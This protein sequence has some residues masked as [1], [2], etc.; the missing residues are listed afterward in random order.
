LFGFVPFPTFIPMIPIHEFKDKKHLQ[1]VVNQLGSLLEYDYTAPHRHDYFELFIFEKGGGTH[2]I[3]FEAFPIHD[4]SIHIVAPGKVHQ[5]NR[6]LNSNGYVIL[7]HAALLND[8][9]VGDFLFNHTCYSVQE[10]TPNYL[11]NEQQQMQICE[12]ANRIWEDYIADH[13]LKQEFVLHHLALL[14]LH[15]LRAR[16]AF[17][18]IQ[19]SANGKIYQ[20]FRKLLYRSFRELKKVKDYAALL[21]V[22][23]KQLN[24][25]V[26]TQTGNSASTL[27]YKQIIMEAQRLLN[28]GMSAKEVAFDLQFDDP[29]HFSKFFKNQTGIPPSEFQKVHV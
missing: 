5:V 23:E 16:P 11:F 29:A 4:R 20:E 22:T 28:T 21:H 27:I 1:I 10:Y 7:F 17:V 24:E 12:T 18:P 9:M 14:C 25:L 26:K 13:A 2:I 19:S 3:D 15:C 6:A 8:S